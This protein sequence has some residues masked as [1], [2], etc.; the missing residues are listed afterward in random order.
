M[1]MTLR[2][3]LTS[4]KANSDFSS[5]TYDPE[6]RRELSF[7][8]LSR[9][10]ISFYGFLAIGLFFFL[11]RL[12]LFQSF[13]SLEGYTLLM[14]L[15]ALIM[16]GSLLFILLFHRLMPSSAQNVKPV[17]NFLF[18]CSI[19]FF[20]IIMSISSGVEYIGTGSLSR[21]FFA[22]V[23]ICFIFA[24]AWFNLLAYLVVGS[25]TTIVTVYLLNG[26]LINLTLNHMHAPAALLVTW[27][28]SR[29]FYLSSARDF[30]I[31]KELEKTNITLRE[32]MAGRLKAM[33]NLEKSEHQ[34]RI[35]YEKAPDA[36]LLFD[37]DQNVFTEINS[38]AED[39]FLLT[40]KEVAG[41]ALHELDILSA[42]QVVLAEAI[43]E[44]TL[45]NGF[46]GPYEF[47]LVRRDDKAVVV[48]VYSSLATIQGRTIVLGTARDITWRR[49]A[50]EALKRSNN[51]L[52]QVVREKTEHVRKA[53]ERL[54]QEISNHKQTEYVL[55]KTEIQSRVLIQKMNDG[56][57]V[58]DETMVFT[59]V[60]DRLCRMLGRSSD[61]LIGL[62]LFDAV[63]P[64][65][66]QHLKESL[67]QP[68]NG[69][70]R[71]YETIL[72]KHDG[73]RIHAIISPESLF[74]NEGNR[75]S[76][77]SV[78]TDITRI[79]AM[80]TALRESEE[81]MRSLINASR[82]SVVMLKEDGTILMANDTLAK[83]L[84]VAP[85]ELKGKNIFSLLRSVGNTSRRRTLKDVAEKKEPLIYEE[86]FSGRYYVLHLY[87][88]IDRGNVVERIAVFARDVTD[89][90]KAEKHIHS[91]SQEL[92]KIQEIERQRISRD[93]HDNVAQELASLK[94]GCDM[95]FDCPEKIDSIL[96]NKIQNFSKI[97]QNTIMSVRNL[98]YDL[99]PPGLDQLGIVSTITNY[100]DEFSERNG[101]SIDFF[102]A[103][104]SE[105][106]LCP[107]T[108]INLYRI[109]QEALHNVKKHAGADQVVIRLIASF[110]TI[111]LRIEDNG[112]GF[113]LKK[114]LET[115]YAEKRMGLRS[116]EERVLLL[117]GTISI[118]SQEEKGTK[119]MVEIPLQHNTLE[120][121][122]NDP[123]GDNEPE[124]IQ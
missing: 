80:E 3:V 77:F 42:D 114:R 75:E 84:I 18:H 2:T 85:D 57:A 93:L 12:A 108:E 76:L 66:I 124:N 110:P 9:A 112:K 27:L 104:M 16:L 49:I 14:Y 65:E 95:L 24:I 59:Y 70:H 47:E 23:A 98:A 88:I 50:E 48:E 67:D 56:F 116:M 83:N 102:S 31:R 53:S 29:F 17:H 45:A 101:I 60:N 63:V 33:E 120:P 6:L 119:I 89:L 106:F 62:S 11:I 69:D 113:D 111:I 123:G 72:V 8:N 73:S 103:G 21:L 82:D 35:L 122:S 54:R 19:T 92:I 100:C 90:K 117:K 105:L 68:V 22:M 97:L 118:R 43:V 38:Y 55:R 46:A 96:A 26:N 71:A 87:P 39:L 28:V 44:A 99:R 64:E 78:I 91:L 107:D 34:F 13:S 5:Q 81:M 4:I 109:T 79:K 7:S 20:I 40:N 32:E 1:C 10:L 41:K 51:D 121:N 30:A 94:I 25:I 74:D 61:D 15:N 37:A 52:Q 86:R 36:F 58:F 115:A